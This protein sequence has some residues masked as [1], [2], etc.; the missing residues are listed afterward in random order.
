MNVLIA[1]ETFGLK[2]SFLLTEAEN[3]N[4][5]TVKC[6][7][8]DCRVSRFCILMSGCNKL[9]GLHSESFVFYPILR[10]S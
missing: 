7:N 4:I 5:R 10:L 9:L 2:N 6:F 1:N 3:K 8:H